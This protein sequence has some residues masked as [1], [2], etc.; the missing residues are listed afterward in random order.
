MAEL[1]SVVVPV[2]NEDENI[3]QCLR[4]LYE[5]LEPYEHEIHICYDFE[6]DTTLTAIES[7]AENKPPTL[8]LTKN[9]LGKGVAFALQAGFDAAKGDA[10]VVTMADL[11]DPP[12]RIPYMVEKIR[13]G[14]DVVSGSRYMKGGSQDGGP[15]LKSFLSRAAGLSLYYVA[16]LGTHDAT[17]NFRAY[18]RRFLDTITV[19]SVSGFEVALELT[20]KAHLKGFVVDEIP[21]HWKDRSAGESRFQLKKWLPK[22]LHWYWMAMRSE[23]QDPLKMTNRLA[24]R[25]FE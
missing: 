14:A 18:S 15:A 3:K 13:S 8:V 16:G 10:V 2:Y 19:E 1:I 17:N 9:D 21:S 12:D 7:M 6:E 20:V 24:S 22:Y 25:V 5:V 23:L 11:S 4:G